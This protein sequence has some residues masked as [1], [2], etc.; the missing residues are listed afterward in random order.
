MEISTLFYFGANISYQNRKLSKKGKTT[1]MKLKLVKQGDFLGTK[2][3]F[4][5]DE[6]S[7]IYMS[8]T[9]I[10]Y[11]LQYKDPANAVLR[12][13]QRHYKRLDAMSIEVKGCQ[14]VTPYQNKDKNAHTFMYSEKGIYEIC[15]HS[16]Q[17][18]ADDFYDWVYAVISSIREHGYYIISE[19]DEKWLGAREESKQVR[20][21][22]TD[23]IKLFVE[24]AKSQGSRNADRYYVI[25]TKLINNKLGIERNQRDSVSQETLMDIKA[26]ETLVKMRIRSL[27][28]ENA[29]YK[30]V[31]RDVKKMVEKL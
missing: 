23:Q 6:E 13:H 25:F 31:Y 4:Y 18:M 10:G 30:E 15:R 8:R 7:N 17:Q 22:E 14:F 28:D 24:Y 20:K 11:A 19:K 27:M 21:Y 9:Q 16:K 26:L 1:V 5:V 12:I 3:D 2:C 29:P